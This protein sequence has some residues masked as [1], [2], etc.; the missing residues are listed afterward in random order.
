MEIKEVFARN[1]VDREADKTIIVRVLSHL[2]GHPPES[3]LCKWSNCLYLEFKKD[4]FPLFT[5]PKWVEKN[6]EVSWD[7]DHFDYYCCSF[8]GLDW[9][10]GVTFYSEKIVEGI[11]YVKVG[12]DYMHS[13][14]EH[15]YGEGDSGLLILK[16]GGVNILRQFKELYMR[17]ENENK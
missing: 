5:Y 14:D 2:T 1:F 9:H 12:C 8:S 13:G 10:G 16:N 3:S 17:L 15:V 4:S 11:T 6:P 7:R